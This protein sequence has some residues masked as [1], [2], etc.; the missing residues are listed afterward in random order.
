MLVAWRDDD[1]ST[2]LRQTADPAEISAVLEK[3]GCGFERRSTPPV[4]PSSDQD[5]VLAAC[6]D[7]IDEI[8]AAEGFV[9]VD[10]INMHPS[11]TPGRLADAKA[12]QNK[13]S[14]EHTHADH[15]VRLMARGSTV[16]YVHGQ[17]TVYAVYAT[18]GDLIRVAS[19]T[20]H[21]VDSGPNPDFAVI[22]F[23]HDSQGWT[24][25]PTDSDIPRRFPDYDA[26]HA[27]AQAAGT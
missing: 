26:V 14:D 11:D 3:L 16:F 12:A 19:G 21:W 9:A 8:N 27:L 22:R 17:D 6:R 5:A 24:R 13:F 7:V 20:T 25:T 23:F 1:P 4:S 2:P 15:E 18:A 10:A